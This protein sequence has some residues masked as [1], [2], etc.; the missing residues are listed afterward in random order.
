MNKEKKTIHNVNNLKFIHIGKCGGTTIVKQSNLEQYHLQRHYKDNEKYIIWIRNPIARF[1]SAFYMSYNIINADTSNLNIK[2]LTLDNCLAPQRFRYKMT[3]NWTFSK[4]YD[5]LVNY[6]KTPNKLA[7]SITSEDKNTK[8][9]AL[10]LMNAKEEH[11]FKGIGWYLHNGDFIEKNYDKIIFI[12]TMENMDDDLM[13]LNNLLNLKINPK[14][15]IR[16]NNNN[17]SKY[18]S[19]KAIENIKNFY[20]NSDYKALQKLVDYNF[21]SKDLFEKYHQYNM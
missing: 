17:N 21:I 3:H 18:L 15:K 6:F 13:K 12:G 5:F 2:N 20:K 19:P 10:E 9:L 4:R 14:K 16:K 8:K 1:V 7:E 11:I